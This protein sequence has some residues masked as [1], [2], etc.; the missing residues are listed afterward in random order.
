LEFPLRAEDEKELR[1]LVGTALQPGEYVCIHPG[2]S[3]PERRW[4][5]ECFAQIARMLARR[6]LRVVLTGGNSETELTR[7]VHRAAGVPCLDLAGRTSLGTLAALLS[8]ARLLICNDTGVSHL[9]AALR[10]PSVVLSTGDNPQR[11]APADG[12]L[13]RV[14]CREAGAGPG[15]AIGAAAALLDQCHPTEARDACDH[16]V[17]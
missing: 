7:A 17:C 3:V 11:W 4:S 10:V 8:N 9:A 1:G 14:L 15:D 6:G 13:H 2:A 5:A 12:L 16:S